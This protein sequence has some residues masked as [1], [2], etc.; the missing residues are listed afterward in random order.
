MVD[1]RVWPGRFDPTRKTA[2]ILSLFEVHSLLF[3]RFSSSFFNRGCFQLKNADY[4][5]L[6]LQ[7]PNLYLPNLGFRRYRMCLQLL[8]CAIV[9]LFDRSWKRLQISDHKASCKGGPE[10]F[11]L[12]LHSKLIRG[13]LGQHRRIVED[14]KLWLIS[15][16][17]SRM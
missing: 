15:M 14:C 9:P 4:H 7:L 6:F 8:S 2:N 11:S 3:S 13:N 16:T 5:P 12:R 10:A 1:C 17:Q